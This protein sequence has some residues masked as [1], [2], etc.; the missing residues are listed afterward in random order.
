MVLPNKEDP[1]AA[2]WCS[3][4]AEAAALPW[5]GAHSLYLGPNCYFWIVPSAQFAAV[6]PLRRNEM[7]ASSPEWNVL[8]RDVAHFK[9]CG[10]NSVFGKPVSVQGLVALWSEYG[11]IAN[12]RQE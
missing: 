8:P 2:G 12:S 7:I 11:V 3:F 4:F 9:I 6:I 10:A 1:T 5:D